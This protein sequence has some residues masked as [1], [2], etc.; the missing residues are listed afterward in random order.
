MKVPSMTKIAKNVKSIFV[1]H[2]TEILMGL[3]I[4]GMITTTF[5]AV[6]ATPKALLI[7]NEEEVKRSK[8]APPPYDEVDWKDRVKLCWR[9][10]IPSAT[11]GTLSVACLVSVT[12]I[13]AKR[14][15][16]LATAYS[17]SE[18]VLK[19]YQEKVIETIGEKKEEL[20]RGEIDKDRVARNPPTEQNIIITNKGDTLCYDAYSD[21][22]YRTDIDRLKKAEVELNRVMLDERY[23]SL[24][25]FYYEVGF[26]PI[27]PG[28]ELG[29]TVDDGRDGRID[30]YFTSQLT[31]EGVPCLVLNF[32]KNPRPGYNKLG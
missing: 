1:E 5:M 29:W 12:S 15:A 3:G 21:R 18:S 4:S 26:D 10:Y 28:E 31:P 27:V 14:N 8:K 2:D 20:L 23:V 17:I 9:C 30:L 22:Y 13:N 25:D 11:I 6:K 32:R 16:A 19:D 24:N 7:I